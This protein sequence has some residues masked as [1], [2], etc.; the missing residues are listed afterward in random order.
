MINTKDQ[1]EL[2]ELISKYI[3]Q[4]IECY[5]LG[6][7]A[8]M[9][10]GYKNTTRDIDLLFQTRKELEVFIEAI[11][12]LGYKE[13]SIKGI[14]PEKRLKSSSK[15][16]MFTRG[17]ERFDLFLNK[18]FGFKITDKIKERFFSRH[19]FIGKK[20]LI[21]KILSKEDIIL[22]KAITKR[23]KDFED[24][25]TIIEQDKDINWDFIIDE[26]ITQRKQNE[27]ILIDL[28]ET[29]KQLKEITFLPSKLFKRIYAE[30]N[31]YR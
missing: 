17:D 16:L 5:A 29:M 30:E 21:V 3:D 9:F 6:G 28:E 11:K 7:T 14:Y 27:W 20:E 25:Q 31:K 4:D 19:D 23:E 15:P 18:I 8:M 22:L 12:Q 26:A 1:G 24:I 10:Y 2:L 13:M